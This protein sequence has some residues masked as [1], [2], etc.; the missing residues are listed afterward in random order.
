MRTKQSPEYW[1]WRGMLFRCLNPKATYFPKYGGRGIAI[2][3]RWM[4]YKNFLEDMKERPSA[5]HSLDR[6]D[7]DRDYEPSNC[8]WATATM[9]SRNKQCHKEPDVGVNYHPLSGKWHAR[10]KVGGRSIPLGL[11]SIKDEAIAARKEAEQ[12]YWVRGEPVLR[13][14]GL[15]PRNAS[16]HTGVRWIERRG[17]WVAYAYKANAQIHL[18]SFKSMDDAIRARKNHSSQEEDKP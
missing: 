10:I 17:V 16:G 18:G 9:Q 6:I 13:A 3:E 4:T 1:A 8:R 7:V 11:Y 5:K 2:C 15:S 14:G 12:K